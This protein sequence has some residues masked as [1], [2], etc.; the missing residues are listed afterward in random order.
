MFTNNGCDMPTQLVQLRRADIKDH[1]GRHIHS[2]CLGAFGTKYCCK[3]E[4]L[5]GFKERY[6]S[7]SSTGAEQKQARLKQEIVSK[8]N[9]SRYWV[10]NNGLHFDF[11]KL[12]VSCFCFADVFSQQLCLPISAGLGIPASTTCGRTQQAAQCLPR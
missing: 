4:M 2:I 11:Y 7:V 1:L 8:A 5:V 3:P 6:A 10:H 12:Q 9:I